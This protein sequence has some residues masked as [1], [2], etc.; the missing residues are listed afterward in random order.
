M[1]T[2]QPVEPVF[3]QDHTPSIID[4]AKA[5]G[6][7]AGIFNF[8][9]AESPEV[10]YF[11]PGLIER[12]DGL[13]LIV[14]RSEFDP[15]NSFGRNALYAI[16][17]KD[18]QSL[19]TEWGKRL[20]FIGENESEHF[21][22]PRVVYHNEQMLVAACS[23]IWYG[24]GEWTGGH[25]VL[26]VF[27]SVP[28]SREEDWTCLKVYR[29]EVGHNKSNVEER[30]KT[31]KNWCWFF[32]EGQLHLHYYSSPWRIAKFT[33][34]FQNGTPYEI[35]PGP[36]WGHGEIRGGTPPILVDGL[37][38]A[39]FHSSVP[40]VGRFRR[41]HMGAIGF[42]SKPPFTP[43]YITPE[44]ILTGNQTDYWQPG[45]PLVV[46]PC[47][48]RFKDG[49]WLIVGGLNDLKSFYLK[50]PHKDILRLAKPINENRGD[51]KCAAPVE[52]QLP[53][54]TRVQSTDIRCNGAATFEPEA[55]ADEPT[56]GEQIREHVRALLEI[57]NGV[58]SRHQRILSELR[59]A[60][61]APQ[62]RRR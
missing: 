5:H 60:K 7:Q 58:P 17:L 16:K 30:S 1:T 39:F 50:L 29:P 13:W 12:P 53:T 37:Y 10:A 6:W 9:K 41:Y 47:G 42:E 25:Q 62:A 61:L 23:F 32:H 19:Q 36:R 4:Q 59:R 55:S 43:L 15:N 40:W 33:T 57:E 54:E 24:N 49:E 45:K 38:W 27:K 56:L 14:R 8:G 11:N 20:I 31:E 35:E 21:E 46:F 34:S 3:G 2:E 22:D 52:I 48:S 26:G 51:V 28:G 44:P 18:D